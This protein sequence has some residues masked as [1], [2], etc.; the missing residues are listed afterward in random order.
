MANNRVVYFEIQADEPSRAKDFYEKAFG[1][2]IEK[3]EMDVPMDYWSITTGDKDKPGID[4]GL[5]NRPKEWSSHTY[6]CTILV[7]DID[8][9]IEAVKKAGGKIDKIKEAEGAEKIE[10]KQIGWFARGTDTEGNRFGI[11]QATEWKP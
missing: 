8:Q 6:D 5:Y 11:M 7:E 10:M 1:W 4:G 2:K 9:A 3:S